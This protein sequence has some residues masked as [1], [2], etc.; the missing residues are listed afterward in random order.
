MPKNLGQHPFFR[1]F[2]GALAKIYNLF[3][4]ARKKIARKS[5]KCICV[6]SSSSDEVDPVFFEAASRLGE[7]IAQKG[8]G[9]VYGGGNAG[10]MGALARS[11]HQ[12]GAGVV[13][14]IPKL[15][16][17]KVQPLKCPHEL[18]VTPDMRERKTVMELRS[19]AFVALPGGYGTLEELMEII[20]LKQLKYHSK[21]IV[22]MNIRGFYDPLLEFFEKLTEGKF[23][24]KRPLYYVTDD[25]KKVFPYIENGSGGKV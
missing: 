12:H 19:D 3:P 17:S 5:G 25:P 1:R 11:A 2:A 23:A 8:Y 6:F 10:L 20:T 14:I 22:V 18:I 21:P 7:L 15:L 16:H 9:L 24:K 4:M 13:G